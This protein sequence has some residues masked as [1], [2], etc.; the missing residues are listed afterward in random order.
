MSS[1]GCRPLASSRSSSRPAASSSIAAS[2]SAVGPD[3]RTAQPAQGEQHRGEPL[4]RSV[5]QVALDAPALGVGDLDEAGPGRAQLP[6]RL[7]AIGDVAKVPG[8]RRRPGERDPGDRQ[9]DRELRAVAAH[10][11]ELEPAVQDDAAAA[12]EEAGEPAPVRVAER[13]RHD[14]LRHLAAD[15]LARRVAEDRL[16][17]AVPA[18]HPAL[19]VHRDDRVE[20]R[21]EHRPQPRLA[22]SHLLLRP[23]PRDELPDLAAERGHRR[24]Q[25]LVG[26][27]QVAGEELH[28]PDHA[29][30]AAQR[31]A[32][33]GVQPG[34]ARRRRARE[35]GV[36]RSVDEPGRLAA[37]QHPPREPLAGAERQRLAELLELVR[38]LA[39]PPGAHA[40]QATGLGVQLPDRAEPPAERASDRLQ[41][42][43]VDLDRAFGFREDPSD[44]MLN[45]PGVARIGDRLA[46]R[47]RLAH[48]LKRPYTRRE[49][50]RTCGGGRAQD[51]GGR[52]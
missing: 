48:G 51:R 36:L 50:R 35:V 47:A 1:A 40:A 5:V 11:G 45:A 8:E 20:R 23:S 16:R 7:H 42:G 18:D 3:V 30:R 13:R 26:L 17:R 21:L 34:P 27:A 15:G 6:V 24:E 19:G 28:H 41:G 4:L 12:L 33:A 29:P 31:E 10:A 32:E 43:L 9:L 49:R 44:G 46:V 25:V 37:R 22:G 52:R 38:P 2:S 14:Q 39:R